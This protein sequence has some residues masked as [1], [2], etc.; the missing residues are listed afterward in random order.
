MQFHSEGGLE[1][2]S[3]FREKPR[4]INL[5]DVLFSTDIDNKSVIEIVGASSTG[6]T[7]LL[8][9][10]IAKCIL[11]ARYKGIKIDGCDACAILINTLGH[12]QMS[13]IAELMT[14]TIRNA[15]QVANVQPPAETVDYIINRS[16]ENLTVISCCNNNQL[17][18]ILHT[19]E[20]EFLSNGKITLL[21]IDNILAYYWQ[22]RKENILTMNYYAT[23][24]LKIIQSQTSQFHTV[25]V[26]TRW[27]GPV[28]TY[29][30]YAKCIDTLERTGV[31]Y[32]LQL[33]K[34]T[35]IR[36]FMCH[37]QSTNDVKQICYTISDS[38]IKWIR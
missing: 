37:V 24:L 4:S 12:V 22:A 6:K 17:Q 29:E 19:L 38:G 35:R 9:Q 2:L 7:V 15:Y 31:N 11:P 34:G 5:D 16:L 21:A 14:S 30:S 23:G 8:C 36:E 10:F 33:S 3:R 18:L 32:K 26:Y 20:D 13:K 25:T 27:D 1:L 28:P